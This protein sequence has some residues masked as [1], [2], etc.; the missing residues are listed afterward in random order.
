MNKTRRDPSKA[1]LRVMPEVDPARQ[2]F[3]GRGLH[4]ERA[5]RSF[6]TLLVERDVLERLGGEEGVGEI[7]RTLARAVGK[8]RRRAA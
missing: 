2:R 4:R 5:R 1:S 7:L 3:L 6:A 8:K